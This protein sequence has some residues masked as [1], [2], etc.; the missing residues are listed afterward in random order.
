MAGVTSFLLRFLL[1]VSEVEFCKD[2]ESESYT[3]RHVVSRHSIMNDSMT[4]KN[5]CLKSAT[6]THIYFGTY[7]TYPQRR[8]DLPK[9]G[10]ERAY[11]SHTSCM[12]GEMLAV[13]KFKSNSDM[14]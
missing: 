8:I 3:I 6:V 5:G 9:V 12:K 11:N 4:T 7:I 13:T 1:L 10:P 2:R 14:L